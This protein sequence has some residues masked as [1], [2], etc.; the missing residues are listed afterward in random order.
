[1]G[2]HWGKWSNAD[3]ATRIPLIMR[4]P[5]TRSVGRRAGGLVEAVDMYP[6]LDEL[7]GLS[8]PPQALDGLSFAPLFDD[9][10]RPWKKA[11]FTR[12]GRGEASV[13]TERYNLIANWGLGSVMLFDLLEDP[14]E[15]TNIAAAR[16][17]VVTEL[18]AILAAGPDAARPD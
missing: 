15:T 2:G 18:R 8:R 12:W 13:K 3:S 14:D 6:T 4:V 10:G 17:D 5:G 11:A 7:C 9:P 16:P 1:D